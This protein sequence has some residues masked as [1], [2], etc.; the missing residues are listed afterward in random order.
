MAGAKDKPYFK[1]ALFNRALVRKQHYLKTKGTY[2][3][4]VYDNLVFG[5]VKAL[6]GGN[7]RIMVVGSAPI[8]GDVLD[9]LKVIFCCPIVEGYGQTETSGSATVTSRDDPIAGQVGG[10]LRCLKIRLRDLPEMK[11]FST[12]KP[13]RGEI[14]FKGS[15]I[16]RGYFKDRE[17]TK[18]AFDEEG[19][20]LSGDVGT[21]LPN[22]SVKIIDRA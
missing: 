18:A 4:K 9:A 5:K 12:D 19:W 17:K 7:I 1:Q 16:F 22:G 20:L 10:P 14:C 21:I 3:H 8:A 15:S 6:L 11:Y 2:S 13:P